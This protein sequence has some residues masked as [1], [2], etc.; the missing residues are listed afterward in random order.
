MIVVDASVA[1]AWFVPEAHAAFAIDL[2]SVPRELVAPDILAAEV[3]NALVKAYRRGTIKAE[4]VR[5]SLE[6]L[7]LGLV[8][9]EPSTP[10]MPAAADLACRLRCSIYEATYIEQARRLGALVVT[11]DARLAELAL[12]VAVRVHRPEDGPLPA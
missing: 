9:M 10:L 11:N 8:A 4:R 5:P 7:T 3:G 1:V 2:I 6:R 12:A